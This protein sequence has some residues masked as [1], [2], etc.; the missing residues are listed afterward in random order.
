M[1]TIRKSDVV[2]PFQAFDY[3]EYLPQEYGKGTKLP[4]VIFLHGAGERGPDIEKVAVHGW[5]KNVRQGQEFP[6]VILAPQCPANK[7]WG[8]YIESLNAFLDRAL[9][10]YDV[11]PDR[12]YLTGLSMGGTG[13][14]LWSQAN[15]ERFAAI[16]PICGT[17]CL[18]YGTPLVGKPVWAFHGDADL[19]VDVMDSIRMIQRIRAAGGKPKLTIYPGVGHGSW[20]PAYSDP[21]VIEWMLAQSLAKERAERAKKEAEKKGI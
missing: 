8:A 7:Y 18:W 10:K 15:P 9:E 13:T 11:D 20:E 12:V 19:T 17:G 21:A 14:W 2:A 3:L 4:L 5:L 16:L 1:Y 6:F